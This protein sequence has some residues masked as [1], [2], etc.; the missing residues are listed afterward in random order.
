MNWLESISAD[1]ADGKK[2]V[3]EYSYDNNGKVEV[4]KDYKNFTSEYIKR[5]YTY[6]TFER[7]IKMVYSDGNEEKEVYEY[8]YDKNNHIVSEKIKNNYKIEGTETVD[9]VRNYDYDVNGRLIKS[10]V[11]NNKTDDVKESEYEY[12]KVGNKVK[13]S[14]N[15]EVT[16][17]IYNKLNQI[18]SSKTAN[19][20]ETVSNRQFAYDNNGN[21]IKAV[22]DV[23]GTYLTYTYDADNRISKVSGTS[24]KKAVSQENLYNGDGKRIKKIEAGEEINYF[25]QNDSVL[26][27]SDKKD[28]LTSYNI[29]G[30]GANVISTM[31]KTVSGGREY[32][33]YNKDVRGSTSSIIDS[34]GTAQAIYYYDDFGNTTAKGNFKNEI[35]YIGGIYDDTTGLYYLNARYYSPED[36]NFM[37][38]DTYR[39]EYTNPATLNFYGYCG[40]NPI[41]YVDPSGHFYVRRWMIA[42]PINAVATFLG[43]GAAYQPYKRI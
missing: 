38:Q 31:R 35:C 39:G 9:E 43:L 13:E 33:T 40:G 37:S 12:D 15:D 18:V 29:Y 5:E 3:R 7:P 25:Y 8:T 6:V 30:D 19:D 34:Q 4:I 22:D 36:G 20:E 26:A 41:N 2:K 11:T 32:F 21:Q 14:I 28:K 23:K 17:N 27:T 10:V 16:T 42:K 1:T 24:E